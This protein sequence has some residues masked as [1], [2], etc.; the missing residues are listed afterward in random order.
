MRKFRTF[1]IVGLLVVTIGVVSALVT[2]ANKTKSV[3][4]KDETTLLGKSKITY[5][6][7]LFDIDFV[8]ADLGW[9]VG[10]W[11]RVFFTKDGGQNWSPQNAG[12]DSYLY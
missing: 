1:F 2:T 12:T 3:E 4:K 6:D 5:R 7:D 10:C 9:T 8:T 11:G